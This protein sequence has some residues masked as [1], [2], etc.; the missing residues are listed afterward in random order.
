MASKKN[1]D[2]DVNTTF[3]PSGTNKAEKAFKGVA[4]EAEGAFSKGIG[5]VAEFGFALQGLSAIGDVIGSAI[6]GADISGKLGAQLGKTAEE[7]GRLGDIAGQIYAE[8]FGENMDDIGAAV[9]NVVRNIGDVDK[10]GADGLKKIS[11]SALVLR[12]TFDIDVTESTNAVGHLLKTGLVADAN[13]GMDLITVAFQKIP[14][15]ANDA[16]DTLNEYSI[17]FKK[18]G[19]DGPKAM[20]LISQGMKA[21]ARDT[22]TVADALKEF[23]IRAIDGTKGTIDGFKSLGLNAKTMAMD[24]AKGGESAS[25]G[26]DTVLDRLRGMKDP[27][28][29]NRIAVELFGTKAE[30]LGDALFALDPSSATAALGEFGGAAQRAGDALAQGPTAKIEAAK[31]AFIGWASDTLA[32]VVIPAIT[33]FVE[34]LN[35]TLIPVLSAMVNWIKENW[36]WLSAVLIVIGAMAAPVVLLNLAMSAWEAITKLVTIAQI[37]LNLAMNAN[38]ILLLVTLIAGLVA[39]FV[40]LWNKSAAF[41]DFFI[42]MWESIKSGI[43]N[44]IQWIKDRWNDMV[45]AFEGTVAWFGRIGS[46]IGTAISNGIKGAI[47]WVIGIIN[48]FVH[49][50]NFVIDGLNVVPGVNIGHIPDIPRLARGGDVDMGGLAVVGER[51]A[52]LVEMPAGARVHSSADSKEWASGGA[53]P[54]EVRV[55]IGDTELT[56]IVRTEI[57][58][59]SDQQ[60]RRVYSGAGRA[61]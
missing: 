16:I 8:N 59:A 33:T 11:E 52:E 26:L 34:L 44:A 2:I 18:L 3:D 20:G 56:H 38:P 10:L 50:I 47:N 23:S 30:D 40:V 37:A 6:S 61:R 32:N 1:I 60:A 54:T 14:D 12:D 29:R 27:V 39:A 49:G 55:F 42:G 46:S 48:G 4:N 7:A 31:R 28:E 17:Q 51:G 57:K 19:L 58:G 13:Q 43:G 41:R 45:Q 53:G 9:S 24:I 21:G 36:N 35:A 25:R 5:K 15:A 22:D